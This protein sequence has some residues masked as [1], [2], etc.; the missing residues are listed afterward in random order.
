M[1]PSV[2]EEV[3]VKEKLLKK[4][5]EIETYLGEGKREAAI[6]VLHEALALGIDHALQV[7]GLVLQALLQ[8]ICQSV[9][10]GILFLQCLRVSSLPTPAVEKDGR[11]VQS[12]LLP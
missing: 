11:S 6:N 4:A 1:T 12:F 9:V 8:A 10:S 5:K 2:P 3:S 7:V